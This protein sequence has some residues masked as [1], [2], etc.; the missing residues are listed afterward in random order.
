MALADEK[1]EIVHIA[2]GVCDGKIASEPRGINGF[3]YDPIF[4][5]AGFDET[6]GELSDDVKREISHRARASGLILRFLLDFIAV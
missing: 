3:G 2:E 4:I 6:F 5:P 1:G